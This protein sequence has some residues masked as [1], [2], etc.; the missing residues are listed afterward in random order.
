[1]S[2]I[3]PQA[4][5]P[6][7]RHASRIARS[8]RRWGLLFLSPWLVGFVLFTGGPM[9]ASLFFSF[10][11]YNLVRPEQIYF[12]GIDN[13][14]RLFQDPLVGQS[15]LVT[16]RF[17]LISLPVHLAFTL[18]LAVLMN[19]KYLKGVRVFRTLFY[20]PQLIPFVASTT[21]WMSVLNTQTGW[22]N[23]ILQRLGVTPPGWGSDP[24]WVVPGLT[25]MGIWGVGTGMI[26]LLA[27]LQN[28]PT[29][30]YDAAIVDGAGPVY[31]FFNITIPMI[32]PVLFYNVV[33]GLIGA[34]QYFLPAYVWFFGGAGPDNAAHFY[35]YYLFKQAWVY[36]E[37]GYASALAWGLF[38]IGLLLTILV[39]STAKRWVYY[40]GSEG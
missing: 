39:F 34:M 28:V 1:M 12:V 26:V 21:I 38:I 33:L 4:M 8:E 19:S 22:V 25:L 13:W 10:M 30:L 31:T 23:R 29:E 2:V 7:R 3:Q 15:L 32:S 14:V 5:Q 18:A 40:A 36:N 27:G 11:N 17:L 16:L 35:M 24:T 37:M 20:M 9:L 6:A